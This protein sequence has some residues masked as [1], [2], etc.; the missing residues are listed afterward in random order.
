MSWPDIF[1]YFSFC[2]HDPP[3][4]VVSVVYLTRGAAKEVKTDWW[5]NGVMGILPALLALRIPMGRCWS[6]FFRACLSNLMCI[7][8]ECCT[9]NYP[10]SLFCHHEEHQSTPAEKSAEKRCW[11]LKHPNLKGWARKSK[12]I[13]SFP[14]CMTCFRF[15]VI[16]TP[17]LLKALCWRTSHSAY[18]CLLLMS[19]TQTSISSSFLIYGVQSLCSSAIFTDTNHMWISISSI[20]KGLV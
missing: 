14:M 7:V 16:Q 18:L 9:A 3:S 8:W 20:P 13:T 5:W 10:S 11:D 19:Y 1:F 15:F 2:V 6:C 4:A 12:I 17:G